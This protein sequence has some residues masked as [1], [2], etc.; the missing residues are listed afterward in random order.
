MVFLIESILTVTNKFF[1][2]KPINH[3][4]QTSFELYV[5]Q[6]RCV[7]FKQQSEQCSVTKIT[8]LKFAYSDEWAI[9]DFN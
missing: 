6:F 3:N 1:F 5:K 4:K 8:V 7:N 2:S 9:N